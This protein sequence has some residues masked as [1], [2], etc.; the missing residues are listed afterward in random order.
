MIESYLEQ[1]A[2]IIGNNLWLAPILSL[3]AGILTSFTPCSLSSIPLVIGFV[4]GVKEKNSKRAF[5][6]SAILSLG[7]SIT[8]VTLGIV[9]TSLHHFVEA[10]ETVWRIILGVLMILMAVQTF[11]IFNFVPSIKLTDKNKKRGYI[12]AFLTG[13]LAGVFSSHC[14]TPVLIALLAIIAGKGGLIW[15]IILMLL[16]SIGHSVLIITA[17]TSVGFVQK[18]INNEKYHKA[19]FILKTILGIVILL[20]GFYMFYLAF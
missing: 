5:F 14:S 15:G 9:A 8:F 7:T 13:L 11:G 19:G 18:I 17:G 6:L 3:L 10:S 2:K 20:I 1:I 16:Y 4:G 12:G